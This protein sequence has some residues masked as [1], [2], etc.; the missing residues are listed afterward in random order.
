M[1]FGAPGGD[2]PDI[3]SAST[4]D[5]HQYP[6]G[7]VG[8]END[9]TLLDRIRFVIDNSDGHW[10]VKHQGLVGK[11]YPVLGNV[12]C[13]FSRIPENRHVSVYTH[14][15]TVGN[16]RR[17]PPAERSHYSTQVGLSLLIRH[18]AV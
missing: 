7:C 13:R 6:P 18:M 16:S 2:Q 1:G 5:D 3:V 8:S 17:Q 15:Y 11:T 14:M 9:K 12:A 4:V 10:V